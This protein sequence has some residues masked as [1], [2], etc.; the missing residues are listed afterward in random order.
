M[1]VVILERGSGWI[2]VALALSVYGP[3]FVSTCTVCDQLGLLHVYSCTRSVRGWWVCSV[4]GWWVRFVRGWFLC[5]LVAAGKV[6]TVCMYV[7]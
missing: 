2:L 3:P 1:E 4:Q 7:I 6:Y 5:A